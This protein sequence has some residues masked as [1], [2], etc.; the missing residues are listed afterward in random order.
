MGVAVSTVHDHVD[1]PTLHA[2][3]E[4]RTDGQVRALS[5]RRRCLKRQS[6]SFQ[7]MPVARRLTK[8]GF[9]VLSARYNTSHKWVPET[10]SKTNSS[11]QPTAM[12]TLLAAVRASVSSDEK[13]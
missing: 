8:N 6:K 7:Q 1:V 4:W 3:R 2:I 11:Y 9:E 10:L 12:V 5:Y 13:F